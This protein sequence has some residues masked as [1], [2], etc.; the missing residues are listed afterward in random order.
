MTMRAFPV[1]YA[2]DVEQV[3]AFYVQLGFEEHFRMPSQDGSPGYVGLRRAGSE[4]AVTTEDSPRTLVGVEPGQ[5][6]RNEMFVYVD[7]LDHTVSELRAGGTRVLRAPTDMPWGERLA[8]LADPE[9]NIVAL[10][11]ASSQ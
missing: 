1:L 6:P 2:K 8:Y 5:G 11:A 10:A 7:D 4:L 3:A 9:G